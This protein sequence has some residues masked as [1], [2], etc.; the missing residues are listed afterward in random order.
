MRRAGHEL[1]NTA[2]LKAVNAYQSAPASYGRFMA[3]YQVVLLAVFCLF[4]AGSCVQSPY[5]QQILL[6]HIP[7]V[8]FLGLLIALTKYWPLSNAAVTCLVVFMVFH[9]V[10]AR[11]IYS[12]V[13]YDEWLENLF[14]F[15][16]NEWFGWT[17]N[18][19]DRLVHFLFGVLLVY[20]VKEVCIRHVHVSSRAASY[21]AVEFILASSVVYELAEWGLA[22]LLSPEAAE[23]YNGQQG[24]MWDAQKDMFLALLGGLGA[25]GLL[26]M[27]NKP[28]PNEVQGQ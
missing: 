23:A 11:Y 4:T 6:Q 15:R 17:R 3:K 19:Y 18:H 22:L 8:M 14:G 16:L 10:G 25:T 13:P 21:L 26:M 2:L 12:Y 28:A 24:D 5:P 7:T 20:P 9:V 1:K 27:I